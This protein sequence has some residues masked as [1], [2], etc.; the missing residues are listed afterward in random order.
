M[1]ANLNLS[2]L[3]RELNLL[4]EGINKT[5]Q[6]LSN[7]RGLLN[8]ETAKLSELFSAVIESKSP[9]SASNAISRRISQGKITELEAK[10]VNLEMAKNKLEKT[11]DETADKIHAV[12]AQILKSLPS[13]FR[14]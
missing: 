7:Q 9:E 10:I 1:S 3:T 6:E 12:T 8:A 5:N 14:P 2:T 4:T 11:Y 13:L